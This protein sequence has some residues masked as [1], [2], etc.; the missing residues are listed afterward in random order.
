[1]KVIGKTGSQAIVVVSEAEER[2]SG[3]AF[4]MSDNAAM[5][6]IGGIG[7]VAHRTN[8]TWELILPTGDIEECET[9]NQVLARVH[10]LV[11]SL[12]RVDGRVVQAEETFVDAASGEKVYLY[13]GKVYDS[14]YLVQ[15]RA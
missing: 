2:V 8:N 7:Y 4:L 15:P 11:G 10:D 3:Y 14:T 5:W 9:M 6:R 13:K 1:M 12:L